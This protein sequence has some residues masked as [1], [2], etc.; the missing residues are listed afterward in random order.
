MYNHFACLPRTY[1][2]IAKIVNQNGKSNSNA[3]QAYETMFCLVYYLK[4][5]DIVVLEKYNSYLSVLFYR[6]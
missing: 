2:G 3:V 5:I 1:K 6:Q 4:E